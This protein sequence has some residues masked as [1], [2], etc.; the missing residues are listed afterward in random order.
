MAEMI[1][2]MYS[3]YISAETYKNAPLKRGIFY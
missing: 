3:R 1:W 2:E